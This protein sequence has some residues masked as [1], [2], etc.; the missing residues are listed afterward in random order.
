MHFDTSKLKIYK[1]RTN[2][3]SHKQDLIGLLLSRNVMETH[4]DQSILQ[5]F[6]SL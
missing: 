6:Y 1:K 3:A 5:C 2:F 4:A